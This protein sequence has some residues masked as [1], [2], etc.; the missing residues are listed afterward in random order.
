M[1]YRIRNIDEHTWMIEEYDKE[2]SV[3]M[4]LLEGE[5]TALLLDTGFG[6]IPLKQIVEELTEK[7]YIVLNTHAHFD[8]VGGNYAFEKVYVQEGDREIY[9]EHRRIAAERI[10]E[11]KRDALKQAGAWKSEREEIQWISGEAVFE[12]GNRTLEIIHTPGHSKGCICVLDK[13]AKRLFTGD[14]CCKAN[15]LLM[16]ED[17]ASVAVYDKTIQKLMERNREYTVTWPSHHQVPVEPAILTQFHEAAELLMEGKEKGITELSPFGE[18]T[19][20]YYGDIGIAYDRI[21]EAS[22]E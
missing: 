20:F 11:E 5:K 12:L 19:V 10:S 6:T 2:N 21:W 13:E 18:M 14:T 3:Y 9:E 22:M 8:H 16:F 4:Y 1:E 17:S 7:P 15:V